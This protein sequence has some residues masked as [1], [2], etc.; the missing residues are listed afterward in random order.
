MQECNPKYDELSDAPRQKANTVPSAPLMQELTPI[1]I[2]T[3][4]LNPIITHL[5]SEN[6]TSPVYQHL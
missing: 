3:V 2:A 6:P 1:A 4:P 5:L